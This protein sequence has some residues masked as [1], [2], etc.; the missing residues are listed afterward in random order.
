M[1]YLFLTIFSLMST[2]T[3]YILL[4]VL[5]VLAAAG[6]LYELAAERRRA[7]LRERSQREWERLSARPE[8]RSHSGK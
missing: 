5:V 3:L 2:S 1:S 7:S 8:A 4:T 6:F